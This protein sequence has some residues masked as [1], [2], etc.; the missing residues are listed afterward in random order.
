M[1]FRLKPR[2]VDAFQWT[3]QPVREWPE[4]MQKLKTQECEDGLLAVNHVGG[5]DLAKKTDWIVSG[6]E[7][8]SVYSHFYFFRD[9]ERI[10]AL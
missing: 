6:A 1:K 2:M 10:K 5:T 8:I 3:G 4:W 9:F 7:K